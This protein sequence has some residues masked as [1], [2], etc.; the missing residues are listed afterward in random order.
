[1]TPPGAVI[2]G[3]GREGDED[4]EG[5]GVGGFGDDAD[6]F[7]VAVGDGVRVV[8]DRGVARVDDWRASLVVL[9][10]PGAVVLAAPP[11]IG[12]E[13]VGVGAPPLPP[14]PALPPG[15]AAVPAPPGGSVDVGVVDGC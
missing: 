10:A 4:T 1:M 3:V 13:L 2:E 12:P 8:L 9:V 6:A 15:V 5:R 11:A 14:P 7:G